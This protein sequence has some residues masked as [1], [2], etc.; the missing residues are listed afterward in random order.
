MIFTG[1]IPFLFLSV[2]L[3]RFAAHAQ[4]SGSETISVA[5]VDPTCPLDCKGDGVCFR[6]NADFSKF[7]AT[8]HS[9]PFLTDTNQNGYYCQ[10]PP[11][12]TGLLCERQFESC[13]DGL[14]FCFHGGKYRIG[15]STRLEYNIHIRIEATRWNC[16]RVH[17]IFHYHA[18]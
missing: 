5:T 11:G 1:R 4:A 12:R 2:V 6:G 17:S 8:E 9:M 18:T 16:M 13:G 10:C 3:A 7:T 15:V 14:H